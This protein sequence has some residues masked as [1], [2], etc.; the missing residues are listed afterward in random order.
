MESPVLHARKPGDVVNPTAAIY[1][2]VLA[3]LDQ[4]R[5]QLMDTAAGL[6]DVVSAIDAYRREVTQALQE[7]QA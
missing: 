7:I 1:T 3:E 6:H 5:A 4:M 2:A